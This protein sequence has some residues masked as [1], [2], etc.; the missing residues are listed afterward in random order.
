M[1][2]GGWVVCRVFKKRNLPVSSKATT[3]TTHE[4][5]KAMKSSNSEN[6]IDTNALSDAEET[7]LKR[8]PKKPLRNVRHTREVGVKSDQDADIISSENFPERI[9]SE[10]TMSDE[11]TF[12]SC[13]LIISTSA[14][15]FDDGFQLPSLICSNDNNDDDDDDDDDDEGSDDIEQCDN[16]N[17]INGSDNNNNNRKSINHYDNAFMSDHDNLLELI[18]NGQHMNVDS[19]EYGTLTTWSSL[20][21]E[22][23]VIATRSNADNINYRLCPD[24]FCN[25]PIDNLLIHH[26]PQLSSL[27]PL[28]E[29]NTLSFHKHI[30]MHDQHNPHDHHDSPYNRLDH[31]NNIMNPSL[32]NTSCD[33]LVD[34]WSYTI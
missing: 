10:T 20:Y 6:V 33:Q 7:P 11:N 13:P 5:S 1:Q 32:Y 14:S 15:I 30:M 22:T 25:L 26:P 34:L 27:N 24:Q 29:N 21:N 2:E 19:L 17:K 31:Y 16:H 28:H 23:S 8:R 3:T 9:K 4:D 12:S 18:H